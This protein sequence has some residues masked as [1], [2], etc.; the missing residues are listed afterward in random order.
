MDRGDVGGHSLRKGRQPRGSSPPSGILLLL[1]GAKGAVGS[2]VAVAVAALRSS[3][4][5][6]LPG[7]TTGSILPQ[8][9]P[10][11]ELELAGWD[12][13]PSSLMQSLARHRVLPA[14]LW[15]P[16]EG[17]LGQFEIRDAPPET[18]GLEERVERLL[19]DIEALRRRHPH[20]CPVLVNLL[21]ACG[22]VDLG[23]FER[24][25]DLYHGA[26]LSAVPDLA[27][28]MAA[29]L[30]A[31]P[32]VNFTSNP[33]EAPAIVR[34]AELRGV[35][36]A[37]RDGK[38]GETYFKVVLASALRA[39]NL[40]VD[41]WYSLNILGNEDGRNLADP[42]RARGKLANKTEV[43]KGVLGYEVGE[44]WDAPSHKV[45]IDY[46]PPRGD[47]KE[48]WDVVDFTGLFG[49]PMSLRVNLMARDSV[50]AAPLVIDLARWVA[51]LKQAG[52]GGLVP[53]LAFYFKRPLGKDPPLRFQDQLSALEALERALDPRHEKAVSGRGRDTR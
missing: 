29:V 5:R 7:L 27:Y 39:R 28:S 23:R 49:M 33:I 32:V 35:P 43:L 48:A 12:V 38:T 44:G 15:G 30:S 50:L 2:T 24:L 42:H 14:D 4:E 10:V 3:P 17:L 26:G 25:E 22:Q 47:A 21:P 53:E 34:E 31:V 13:S 37:G 16:H 18:L 9:G 46:Y 19:G 36:M 11:G 40:K 1:A 45:H 8:L 41:G 51:A 6:V 20:H 52:R